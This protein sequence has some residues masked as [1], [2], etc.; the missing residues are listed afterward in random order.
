MFRDYRY[1]EN[2]PGYIISNFGE[3]FSI[4]GKKVRQLKTRLRNG[5]LAIGLSNNGKQISH[6]IHALVGNA[7]I[8]LRTGE[9][10][11]DHIDRVKLNNRADNIRLATKAE[12]NDNRAM[13]KSNTSGFENIHD[14]ID[15]R[16]GYEYYRLQIERNKKTLI[17]Q[18]YKKS[19]YTIEDV[20][21]IRDDKI[22]KYNH[23]VCLNK[24]HL[25]LL[26]ITDFVRSV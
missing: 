2:F 23:E 18:C 10:T 20:V 19:D 1:I 13:H 14:F 17:R 21:K 8:G 6:N 22:A 25:E 16:Y 3:V 24:V 5:Y 11:F 12:Q 9:L 26:C 15:K 4:K 7:F